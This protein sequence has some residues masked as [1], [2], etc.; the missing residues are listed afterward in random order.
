[1][2]TSWNGASSLPELE[3]LLFG[4]LS[5]F[6]PDTIFIFGKD[7][8]L[9]VIFVLRWVGLIMIEDDIGNAINAGL[10]GSVVKIDTDIF[11]AWLAT[12]DVTKLSECLSKIEDVSRVNRPKLD[13]NL[14]HPVEGE[15]N[16]MVASS[17]LYW[18][19]DIPHHGSPF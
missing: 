17:Q 8:L 7:G 1:M 9:L 2:E 14:L 12:E 18:I 4:D 15:D 13:L 3:F 19:I 16:H 6:I 10:V 11:E 5:Q